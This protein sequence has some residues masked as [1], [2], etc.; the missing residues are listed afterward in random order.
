MGPASFGKAHPA[1]T[2]QCFIEIQDEKAKVPPASDEVLGDV[3]V[4]W[5]RYRFLEEIDTSK[6][7]GNA[8]HV[9]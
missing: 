8:F 3:S 7:L 9:N 6:M 1:L 5:G 4:T 2:L